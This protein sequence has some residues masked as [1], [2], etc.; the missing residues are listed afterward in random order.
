MT[1]SILTVTLLIEL[2]LLAA[3]R[4]KRRH[5]PDSPKHFVVRSNKFPR[6]RLNNGTW[7]ID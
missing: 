3:L 2:L 4:F 6:S 7:I 5:Q 1:Q